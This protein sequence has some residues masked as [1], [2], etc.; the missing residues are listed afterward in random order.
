MAKLQMTATEFECRMD[1]ARAAAA[2]ELYQAWLRWGALIARR[3]DPF[4]DLTVN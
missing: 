1:W 4:L 2:W 3:P